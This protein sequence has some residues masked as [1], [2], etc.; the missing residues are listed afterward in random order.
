MNTLPSSF[1]IRSFSFLQ[2][3]RICI[4]ACLEFGF[5]QYHTTYYGVGCPWASEKLMY[6]VVNTLA[7]SF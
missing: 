1:L 2:V 5:W 3:T 7:H 6:N 4:K